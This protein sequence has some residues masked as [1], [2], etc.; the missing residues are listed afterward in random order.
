[1]YLKALGLV[2]LATL[3]LAKNLDKTQNIIDHMPPPLRGKMHPI[4]TQNVGRK[5]LNIAY[6]TQSQTQKLDL[7]WAKLSSP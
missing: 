5:Y 6:A 3:A 1:M 4:N 7:E 2:V